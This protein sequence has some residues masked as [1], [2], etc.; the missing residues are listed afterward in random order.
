V[1]RIAALALLLVT[2]ACGAKSELLYGSGGA[3]DGTGA[4]GIGGAS[5][6]GPGGAGTGGVAGS[7]GN[8]GTGAASGAAGSGGQ[9][10]WASGTTC[11]AFV[12]RGS[13]RIE[14]AWFQQAPQLVLSSDDQSRVT[15]VWARDENGEALEIVHCD[16]S[17]QNAIVGADGVSRITDFGIA[18]AR[19]RQHCAVHDELKGKLAYMARE[20][21]RHECV[22]A[23]TDVY[24][25]S[26]VLWEALTGRRLFEADDAGVL[27][28]R[29]VAAEVEAPSRWASGVPAQL[30]F[31]VMR[32]LSPDPDARFDSAQAMADALRS[33]SRVASRAEVADWLSAIARDEL[34]ARAARV[35]RVQ[36]FVDPTPSNP[37]IFEAPTLRFRVPTL[38]PL[39]KLLSKQPSVAPVALDVPP[40]GPEPW[41]RVAVR[42]LEATLTAPMPN[43]FATAFL[44]IGI[45]WNLS[46]GLSGAV[47]ATG[48]DAN[49]SESVAALATPRPA[50]TAF[51]YDP[52]LG[53]RPSFSPE[54]STTAANRS[55]VSRKAALALPSAS[56]PGSP[57]LRSLR[58]SLKSK[59]LSGV[60]TPAE[61]RLLRGLCRQLNDASCSRKATQFEICYDSIWFD[62]EEK[63]V[64]GKGCNE[65][66][67]LGGIKSGAGADAKKTPAK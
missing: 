51:Q 9:P 14:S 53:A 36:G 26:V 5:S 52:E 23:R 65:K 54:R 6:N 7:S 63:A 57:A 11:Y 40:P 32:G 62:G 47:L 8:A 10:P 49:R 3:A 61:A 43:A 50:P 67:P 59:V 34:D 56:A 60:A 18:S 55:S 22:D 19:E 2:S 4:A 15:I 35:R 30:D 31:V 17:P 28:A 29:V 42:A 24:G 64:T 58:D 46:L 38:P 21:L 44:V 13:R 37:A 45:V 25:A 1:L 27:F 16:V 12:D 39:P 66:R 48:S 41:Q 20:Q 33:A